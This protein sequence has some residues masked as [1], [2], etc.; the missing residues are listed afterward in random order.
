MNG[1]RELAGFV[2]TKRALTLPLETLNRQLAPT[3]HVTA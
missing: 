1:P 3:S 2:M